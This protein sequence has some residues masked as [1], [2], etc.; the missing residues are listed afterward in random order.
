MSNMTVKLQIPLDKS[1]RDAVAKHARQLGFNSVQDFTRVM[2][3]TV[4]R[5][6]MDFSLSISERLSP[7]AEARYEKMLA[8]HMADKKLAN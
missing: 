3:S 2:Y 6:K 4:V 8:E 7:A 5:N 1:L